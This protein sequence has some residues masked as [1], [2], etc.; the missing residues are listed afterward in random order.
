MI[1]SNSKSFVVNGSLNSSVLLEVGKKEIW[2]AEIPGFVVEK[3]PVD[4]SCS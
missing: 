2:R 3:L 4:V 1:A